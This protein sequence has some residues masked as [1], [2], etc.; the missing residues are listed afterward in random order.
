MDYSAEKRRQL[1]KKGQAMSNPKGGPPRFPIT[2]A[3]SLKAA[4][5]LVGRV[6]ASQ[7]GAVRAHIKRQAARLKLTSMIPDG[8]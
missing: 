1:K 6:P 8:W 2:N 5:R 7:R 3:E 4:I